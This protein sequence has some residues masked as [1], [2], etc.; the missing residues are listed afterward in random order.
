MRTDPVDDAGQRNIDA[1]DDPVENLYPGGLTTQGNLNPASQGT[2][3]QGL[4]VQL[5][6]TQGVP[7]PNSPAENVVSAV[8][9]P[10]GRS[11]ERNF[12]TT[13]GNN[14]T[15]TV[16]TKGPP[17]GENGGATT[18]ST[19]NPGLVV[20]LPNGQSIPDKSSATGALMSPSADLS[21]VAAA[22]R[23]TGAMYRSL[24]N[25]PD[26]SDAAMLFLL[27]SLGAA[28]GHGG[29]FDYQRRGNLLTG[30]TQLP[31][32]RNVSNVNVGLFCQ[33]AGLTLDETLSAGG[34]YARALSS[35][36]RPHEPHG[37][38]PR[39]IQFTTTGFKLGQSGMFD[40]PAVP[41]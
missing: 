19:A 35:N 26:A 25:N 1:A 9:G 10:L 6:N 18:Q 23:Q 28:L 34:L 40:G 15:D 11:G 13:T 29:T 36:A 20:H 24:L 17:I 38:D 41:Q 31:Q 16:N 32:F 30:Y 5:P 2:A 33:Q 8:E 7:V 14:P 3:N 12:Y 37:L 27:A 22:G 39:N 4:L 21:A